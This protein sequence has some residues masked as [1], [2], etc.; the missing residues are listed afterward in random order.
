M[1]KLLHLVLVSL[2][3]IPLAII[4][5]SILFPN[6]LPTD[7]CCW[8]LGLLPISVAIMVYYGSRLAS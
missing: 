1:K 2:I 5:W 8:S 3:V 4:F 7:L 6:S